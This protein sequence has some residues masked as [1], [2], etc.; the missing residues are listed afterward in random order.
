MTKRTNDSRL[1]PSLQ[2]DAMEIAASAD[3][4]GTRELVRANLAAAHIIATQVAKSAAGIGAVLVL[5][6]LF[7]RYC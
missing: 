6:A 4:R 3:P 5:S 2:P 1:P 7:L